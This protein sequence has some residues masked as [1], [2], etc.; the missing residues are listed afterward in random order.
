MRKLNYVCTGRVS[1]RIWK[2]PNPLW[3][4]GHFSSLLDV[5]IDKTAERLQI[6]SPDLQCKNELKWKFDVIIREFCKS[7]LPEFPS[8][9][10]NMITVFG[11]TYTCQK[12]FSKVKI[13]KT[14]S[15]LQ[16][17]T[18]F[19]PRDSSMYGCK[20]YLINIRYGTNLSLLLNAK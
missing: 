8:D 20:H 10:R 2:H 11:S 7:Y 5:N 14:I 16:S 12:L 18:E 13:R 3:S 19:S 15:Y 17:F 4:N 6:S 9:I 1:K